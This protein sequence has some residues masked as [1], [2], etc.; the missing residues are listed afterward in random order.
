ML[1]A[2]WRN[3]R[4]HALRFLL[5]AI[6]IVLGVGFVVGTLIFTDTLNRTFT[7]LFSQVSSDVVVQ[8]KTSLDNGTAGQQAVLPASA[9]DTVSGSSGVA[10]A[11]GQVFADGVTILGSDGK[12]LG[13][14]GAPHFGSNWSDDPDLSPYRLQDGVGPST[15]GEVA[16]DSVSAD[17]GGLAVGDQV[18]LITTLQGRQTATIV[19][20]FSYGTSGN[21]AGATIA[22]FDMRTAQ[23]LLLGGVRGYTEIDATADQGV[24]QQTATDTVRGNLQAAGVE[25]KVVTGQQAADDA[26]ASITQGLSFIN[27]FLLVFAGISLFVGIFIILNTFAVV[28]GQRSRELALL[29]AVGAT[30]RQVIQS[31]VVE[32][33][34]IG[35]VGA[36]VG[37]AVGVGVAYGLQAL[38]GALGADIPTSGLVLLPRTVVTAFVVGLTVTVLASL[39]PAW[40]ASRVP[41]VAAMRDDYV[42]AQRSLRVRAVIGVVLALAAVT[43]VGLGLATSTFGWAGLG[44]LLGLVAAIVVS[45]TVS[46]RVVGWLGAVYRPLFGV[47]G[48]LAV[49]SAQRQ[50]RRTAA[51]ASAL[52]IG[53]ALVSLLTVFATSTKA[54]TDQTLDR[55]LGADFLVYG[56]SQQPFPSQVATA[57]AAVDGVGSVSAV[58]DVMAKVAG[59]TEDVTAVDP[60]TIGTMVTLG[61]A[62]GQ[63]SDLGG[64][65]IGVDDTTAKDAGLAIGDTVPVSFGGKATPYRITFLYPRAGF[66]SGWVMATSTVHDAGLAPGDTTVY[67]K[68]AAGVDPATL[69]PALTD[70]VKP[71]PTVTVQDQSQ[72][73]QQISGSINQLL[74]VMILLLGLAIFIAI[75]GIVNTLVLTV[76]ER[77]RELGM[78]RAVGATRRQVGWM[79]VLE[80]VVISV[81]GALLGVGLGVVFAAVFQHLLAADGISVLAIPWAALIAFV[82]LAALIGW[83]AALWPA[84]RAGRIDVLRAVTT[85]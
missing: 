65:T 63:L 25:A 73:K 53:L 78:L 61:S 64:M 52:M 38:F 51:T 62:G 77:T 82:V 33:A 28:V 12:P 11:A 45:P 50:P 67:V 22:A 70:A 42:P 60:A 71:Y 20:I 44:V 17:K 34:L 2:S 74:A 43:S 83:V 1:R 54:S 84:Y 47:V 4:A 14:Q 49:D 39:V 30:R 80:A 40:R 31:V 29:R 3:V 5:S 13:V 66:F 68:A 69:A 81:Y 6:A 56:S 19:G 72:F 8:P 48:R 15:S 55:V 76:I 18:T 46:T 75:L 41:P 36:A 57:V 32:A 27:T 24:S 37:I 21:L 58:Q 85:D 10:S 26:T 79:V 35:V 23:D 9:L 7:D 59:S 16:I